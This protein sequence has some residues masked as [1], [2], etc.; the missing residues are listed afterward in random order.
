MQGDANV[1]VI[2]G[3]KLRQFREQLGYSLKALAQRTGLS[4]SY[5][6]EIEK[7]KKYPK[8]EKI[9]QL[10]QALN[11]SYDDLVSL[12]L[13][14]KLNPLTSLL[15]S[16][17]IQEFPFQMFGITPRHVI[18]LVTRAPN[19]AST[20]I[21][22][23]GEIAGSYDMRVEH[24]FYAALRSH[25]QTHQNY[26]A[27]LEQAA[28]SFV[29]EQSWDIQPPLPIGQLRSVLTDTYGY[30]LDEITLEQQPELHGFRSVWIDGDPPQLL[31]N[32]RLLPGQ[33]A[34]VLGREIG[35]CYLELR[36][37]A[38]TSSPNEVRSFAQVL[39]DFKASVFSGALLMHRDTLVDDLRRFFALPHWDENAFLTLLTR[40]DVTPEMF[41]Y[42]LSELI[43][44]FL[45]LPQLHFLRLHSP[46]GSERYQLTKHLNM[47]Q[48]P[49]PHGL[50]LQEH[51]CRRWLSV[52]VL[53]ELVQRQQS[54]DQR[55]P[56][57]GVQRS[58]FLDRDAE[59]FC[60][61]LARPLVLTPTTNTSV[62]IGFQV[63]EAFKKI[64]RF[65]DD[66]AIPHAEINETCERCRL[67]EAA[68]RERAAPATIYDREQH[69]A[70]RNQALHQLVES[71]RSGAPV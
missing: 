42:R 1:R 32:C 7:G 37:R 11:L 65:W 54:G 34:F 8:A 31:L 41:F 71:L 9:L 70:T 19:E 58:R 51:Y 2:F 55:A 45:E 27:D 49:L 69:L 3:M 59:Y 25:Q 4:P 29:T 13:E 35:Y 26:F 64:V 10:A 52:E 56:I 68:C 60:I 50:G 6:T 18:D 15:D 14:N 53:R 24:F 21:R 12:K 48:L 28:E 43:P 61:S 5:L 40:Y 57:V 66:P 22:T 47:S 30:H 67:S 33:K 38:M 23:L 62:T 44:T 39:N 36:D 16:P 20:L 17:L 46:A 63:D